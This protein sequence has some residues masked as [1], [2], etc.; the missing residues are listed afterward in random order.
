[1]S[2]AADLGWRSEPLT[3]ENKSKLTNGCGQSSFLP[4]AMVTWRF[5]VID[6]A[7]ILV[8]CL[9]WLINIRLEWVLY[10]N[11]VFV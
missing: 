7:F 5:L 8:D 11:V 9:R 4:T 1:M 6:M 3:Q 10:R 2:R